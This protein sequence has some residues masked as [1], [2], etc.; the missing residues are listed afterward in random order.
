MN[1]ILPIAIITSLITLLTPSAFAESNKN[2]NRIELKEYIETTNIDTNDYVWNVKIYTTGPNDTI[3]KVALVNSHPELTAYNERAKQIAQ[4][5]SYSQLR[6]TA[7]TLELLQQNPKLSKNPLF[8]EQLIQKSKLSSEQFFE[9][10]L[11][12]I[13]TIEKYRLQPNSLNTEFSLPI[14]FKQGI[15][16]DPKRVNRLQKE[17]GKACGMIKSDVI[18]F[19]ANLSMTGNG[20]VTSAYIYDSNIDDGNLSNHSKSRLHRA[21]R[22]NRII[23][24]Y[25]QN[26]ILVDKYYATI[27]LI[28]HCQ[29]KK[30]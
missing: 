25:N 10:L 19:T 27:P 30:S 21:L 28:I 12:G 29:S 22:R 26:G 20:N 6:E 18:K 15:Q 9:N 7:Y 2:N 16:V 3:S 5:K 24:P 4:N 11:L 17:A 1:K 23:Y 8:L 13:D 14:K